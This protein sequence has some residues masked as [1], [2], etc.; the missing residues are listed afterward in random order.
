MKGQSEV[1]PN[2][3]QKYSHCGSKFFTI[4]YLLITWKRQDKIRLHA[5]SR[6]I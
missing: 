5:S 6:R 3:I 2:N 1:F 4:H